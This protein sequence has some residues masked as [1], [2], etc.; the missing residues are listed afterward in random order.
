MIYI[1]AAAWRR[2]ST[3]TWCTTSASCAAPPSGHIHKRRWVACCM[4]VYCSASGSMAS[5]VSTDCL[6]TMCHMRHSLYACMYVPTDTHGVVWVPLQWPHKHYSLIFGAIGR[7]TIEIVVITRIHTNLRCEDTPSRMYII[8][9]TGWL[10]W[11]SR[12]TDRNHS[13]EWVSCGKS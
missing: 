3:R 4:Y 9:N 10:C 6:P 8:H 5:A 12:V 2:R 13:I 1:A 7:V 11:Q